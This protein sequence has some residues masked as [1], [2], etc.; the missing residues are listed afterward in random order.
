MLATNRNSPQLFPGPLPRK[1]PTFPR[2]QSFHGSAPSKFCH[3]F[4]IGKM[5]VLL[6]RE[7]TG[8]YLV[9]LRFSIISPPRHLCTIFPPRW[10]TCP[11]SHQGHL[12]QTLQFPHL[13]ADLAVV[14]VLLVCSSRVPAFPCPPEPGNT[15]F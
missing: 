3:P 2:E 7:R 6:G 12:S 15:G 1:D 5:D 14:F 11:Q 9:P 8:S 10:L 4:N 13:C